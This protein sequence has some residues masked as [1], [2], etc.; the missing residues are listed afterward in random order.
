MND[1]TV[2]AIIQEN[3]IHIFSS[4]SGGYVAKSMTKGIVLKAETLQ[5]LLDMIKRVY[6]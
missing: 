5:K 4:P 3:D 6:S 2:F 1:K